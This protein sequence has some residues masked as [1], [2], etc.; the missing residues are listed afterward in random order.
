METE[1]SPMLSVFLSSL[2]LLPFLSGA[3]SSDLS[4]FGFF[5]DLQGSQKGDKVEGIHK[6]KKYLQHFGYL[7]STHS[8]TETQVDS[9][10]HFDDALESA[11]KAFQTYYHLK[12]TGVLDAPTATQMSRTRCGVPDNPPVTNNINSHGHS[13]LNIGTHYAFFPN[14]PR[15]PAGKRH[16]LYSLD[17]ASHPEAANAVANAFGAWAGVTNFTFERTSDPK[18]ANLYISF[19]VRDHGDGRPFDGRGGILAHA[20]APTD[21]RF[22]FDGDETWVIGAVAN[23][24]DLQTVATHEIGHLLGLAHTP[25]QEAIMY[26]IISPGVTKGLNQ[27]DIDGIRALY[28]G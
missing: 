3:T 2:L 5:K 22:H 17:S 19:K 21:G 8:Q 25:V 10:D 28:T 11:I 1:V 6:V 14:K 27:D 7:G 20:F 23:S 9:E 12:P 26:A 4:P 13:H 24:M 18:I 15:W 16:L